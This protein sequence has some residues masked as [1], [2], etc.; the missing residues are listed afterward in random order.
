MKKNDM[1]ALL[2]QELPYPQLT[3]AAELRFRES[4]SALPAVRRNTRHTKPRRNPVLRY[5]FTTAAA[6][7]LLLFGLNFTFPTLAESIPGLGELFKSLNYK[8]AMG[9]NSPSYE[10]LIQPVGKSAG[11]DKCKITVQEAY[12]EGRYVFMSLKMT[13]QDKTVNTAEWLSPQFL[14]DEK[15]GSYKKEFQVKVNGEEAEMFRD[16]VFTKGED[17][18]ESA[19]II[20]L[21]TAAENGESLNVDIQIDALRGLKKDDP[22]RNDSKPEIE[23]EETTSL[24]FDVQVNTSFNTQGD[25]AI[26]EQ[27]VTLT[28]YESNPSYFA[29]V[30][31]YPAL[32]VPLLAEG[33]LGDVRAV[34]EDGTQLVPNSAYMDEAYPPADVA[35]GETA[36]QLAGF[37]GV[38]SG[39][40]KVTVTLYN[41]AP[42][43]GGISPEGGVMGN[44]VLG[45]FTVNLEEK[46]AVPTQ[47]YK[48]QG[49]EF[50]PVA[51]YVALYKDG[52]KFTNHIFVSGS[53]LGVGFRDLPAED[54][55]EPVTVT[56]VQGNFFTDGEE[57]P[58]EAVLYLDGKEIQTVVL[59]KENG[60]ETEYGFDTAGENYR[61]S[62]CDTAEWRETF[63]FPQQIKRD[64]TVSFDLPEYDGK[65]YWDL[66]TEKLEW[67]LRNA[68]TKEILYDSKTPKKSYYED[69]FSIQPDS[70]P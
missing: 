52:P 66:D 38:P 63:Q 67:Q 65:K 60:S 11:T 51:D 37:D 58:L 26:E 57:K 42:G 12:S 68:E 29:V 41:I 27:G 18:F 50:C 36:T 10:N 59:Q 39:T 40:K 17:G 19:A 5:V 70:M 43:G 30:L 25:P 55:A 7:I 9:S 62:I 48:E 44:C 45:E 13:S 3:E 56:S 61:F 47:H 34:T 16:I 22:Y 8:E 35:P 15:L 23:L 54:G 31:K 32:S 1:K 69:S 2:R 46:T 49:Y 53:G 24:S 64:Y 14:F 33:L 6:A 20:K 4:L 28:H 21:P